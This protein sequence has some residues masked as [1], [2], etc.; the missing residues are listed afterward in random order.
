MDPAAALWTLVAVLLFLAAMFWVVRIAVREG[1]RDADRDRER[2][3][4]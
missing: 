2:T 4:R 3:G 1:I